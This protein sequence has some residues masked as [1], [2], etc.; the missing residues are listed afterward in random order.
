M[1]LLSTSTEEL[2][3]EINATNSST[4]FAQIKG[5]NIAYRAIGKGEPIIL[6]QRF[7]GNL[8]DW[9]PA[10]LDQLA[11]HYRVII[12]N[13]SGM[14]SSTGNPGED[15]TMFAGD[16]ID[17]ADSLSI[18]QFLLGGW[19]FG[20]WVAQIVATEFSNRVKQLILLGTKPPGNNNF[21]MEEIFMQTA[22]ILDYTLEHEE[23]LFFEPIS[24]ASRIAAKESHDRIKA[25]TIDRDPIVKPALWQYYGKGNDDYTADPYNARE[26]LKTTS[27]PILVISGDHEVC[28]PP[29]NWFELN[30]QLPTTCVIVIPRAGHGPH[31]QHPQ[32]VAQFIHHFIADHQ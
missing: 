14:A 23:I 2:V 18:D 28:F 30:R 13:Y 5:R 8:D 4:Q 24:E 16:V 9:D 20:G 21:P 26:K 27:V 12:F 10:F 1:S 7:R 22:Y 19:S 17:L 29:E 32:M 15:M 3:Q 25:R 31:H 6:C 11:R